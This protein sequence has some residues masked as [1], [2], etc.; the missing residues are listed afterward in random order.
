[1]IYD[2]YSTEIDADAFTEQ[3]C[4]TKMFIMKGIMTSVYS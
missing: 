3:I 1:M 2:L 4:M